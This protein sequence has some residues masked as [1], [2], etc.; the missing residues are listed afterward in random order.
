MTLNEQKQEIMEAKARFYAWKPGDTSQ[1]HQF[2]CLH[3]SSHPRMSEEM[4]QARAKKPE[5]FQ[6]VCGGRPACP[7]WKHYR[8]LAKKVNGD[9]GLIRRAYK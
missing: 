3:I 9:D 2:R 6:D 8:K 1:F 4:C 5:I 7:R